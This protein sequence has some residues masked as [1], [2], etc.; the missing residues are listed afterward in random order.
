MKIDDFLKLMQKLKRFKIRLE[1][2]GIQGQHQKIILKIYITE[3]TNRI[4]TS[5]LEVI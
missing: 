2:E 1:E 3:L 4:N 5:M